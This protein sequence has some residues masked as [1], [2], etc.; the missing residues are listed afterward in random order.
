MKVTCTLPH[1]TENINGIDFVRQD[2]Q[3][4]IAEGLSKDEAS[5]F[6]DIPGYT[7]ED[8]G[9]ALAAGKPGEES[10]AGKTDEALAA[11]KT[12]K[13]KKEAPAA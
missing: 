3:S 2:D 13:G 5:Q 6:E 8:D 1:V 10:D 7:V 9:E 11:S 4:V 12:G